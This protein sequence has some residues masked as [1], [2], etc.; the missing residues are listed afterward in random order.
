MNKDK[1]IHRFFEENSPELPQNDDFMAEFIRQADLL[2]TPAS[3]SSEENIKAK[4]ALA[5]L[6]NAAKK[7]SRRNWIV[8]AC[9]SVSLVLVFVVLYFGIYASPFFTSFMSDMA[10]LRS[11]ASTAVRAGAEFDALTYFLTSVNLNVV[12]V[13][14]L[15]LV[16]VAGSIIIVRNVSNPTL[17]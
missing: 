4:E 9:A 2:P 11:T 14:L 7:A 6:D 13:V 8:A 3:L 15:A 5:L 16:A 1:K 10:F 12:F 17:R